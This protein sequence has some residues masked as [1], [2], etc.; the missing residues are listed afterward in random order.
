MPTQ[1]QMTLD[2]SARSGTFGLWRMIAMV[3][4]RDRSS[5]ICALQNLGIAESRTCLEAGR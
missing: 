1:I 4:V 3:V 5:E 2:I